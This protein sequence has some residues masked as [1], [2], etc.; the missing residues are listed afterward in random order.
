[1]NKRR[2]PIG[3]QTFREIRERNHDYV[4]KTAY[5]WCLVDQGKHYFPSRPRR[6]GKSLFLDTLKDLFK[7]NEPL[8]RGLSIHD[9]W[10][11]SQRRP[12]V[13]ISFG[14]GSY[15]SPAALEARVHQRLA[16][17]EQRNGLATG[18]GPAAGRFAALL[19]AFDV[20]WA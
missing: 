2:L 1:M 15:S 13:R 14:G 10:D 16:A 8:F 7:G 5:A 4:D 11:W 17:G 19:E 12:V 20:E 3:I 9:R 6:F 18:S